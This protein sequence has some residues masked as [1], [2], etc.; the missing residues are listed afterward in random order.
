VRHQYR[1]GFAVPILAAVLLLAL[2]I[3]GTPAAASQCNAMIPFGDGH[4][5]A[6]A[7]WGPPTGTS[8]AALA[9][10][11]SSLY[12]AGACSFLNNELWIV[13]DSNYNDWLEQGE[14]DGASYYSCDYADPYW[15]WADNRPC[16]GYFEHDEPTLP[17]GIQYT[18]GDWI[19]QT[20]SSPV[21]YTLE[22]GPAGGPFTISVSG[23]GGGDEG[24][25]EIVQAGSETSQPDGIAPGGL[26]AEDS[27]LSYYLGGNW[28]TGWSGAS[29]TPNG[30]PSC[31]YWYPSYVEILMAS[32]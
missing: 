20:S 8:G 1:P 27:S 24:P 14:K 17:D 19:W 28:D 18:Y 23:I 22:F 5:Y 3:P 10:Y 25:P 9:L 30:S 11:S 12:S 7:T 29:L 16:C 26:E 21:Q 13:E 32:C 15:F 31:I 6:T 4:C 2:L